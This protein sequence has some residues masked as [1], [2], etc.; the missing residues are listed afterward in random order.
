MN[1]YQFRSLP[2]SNRTSESIRDQG[3]AGQ[4]TGNSTCIALIA[5]EVK[6]GRE[7]KIS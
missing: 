6:D 3:R 4:K 2:G 7:R 1:V 5:K